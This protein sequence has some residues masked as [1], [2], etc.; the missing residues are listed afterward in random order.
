MKKHF[1][2]V[3]LS[4]LV[5]FGCRKEALKNNN[6]VDIQNGLHV[7]LVNGNY[8]TDT[9]GNGL[10]D[11]IIVKVTNNGAPVAGYTVQ[12]TRSGCQDM[13]PVQATSGANGQASFAWY[14]SG[15]V[16]NQSLKAVLLD[17]YLD[18]RDSVN[19]SAI[20]IVPSH[21]WHR[22]G[23]LQ[24]FPVNKV[25]ALASGRIL[26]SVNT[27]GF[28]YYSDDNAVSWHP[29]KTFPNTY[30]ITKIM[31]SGSDTFLATLND[32]IYHSTDNGQTWTLISG[33]IVD[34]LN[35]SDMTYTRSGK[36]IFANDYGVFES[37]DKGQTWNENDAGLPSGS[38]TYPV[39]QT[40]G[41]MYII[42]SDASV[43]KLAVHTGGWVNI[44]PTSSY[45][46]SS[47]ESLYID[48]TGNMFMSGPHDAP[49]NTGYIYESVDNG[50]SWSPVFSQQNANSTYADIDHISQLGSYYYFS[51][52]GL[53][54]FRTSDFSQYTDMTLQFGNIGVVNYTVA[55]NSSFVI[56][57]TGYGVYYYTK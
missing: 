50:L 28:P 24:N 53:G 38:C 5:F 55:A 39:E 47:A 36:L 26:A 48:A 23:C 44:G 46:L 30:F 3:I 8:Q 11:S 31:T 13:T 51:F 40:N 18:H 19:V 27:T 56:G 34:V 49:S 1:Y 20:G 6:N 22:G 4:F 42:G 16:G 14:L 43:Y 15:D 41:D 2:L 35:F 25:T 37:D 9:I 32:G 21:G 12:F 54:I 17:A 29:L 7:T 52:A 45:L 33:G 57:T 10:K